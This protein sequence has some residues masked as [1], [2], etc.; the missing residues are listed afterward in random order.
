M[1]VLI[2]NKI[3]HTTENK[4]KQGSKQNPIE[5]RPFSFS[6]CRLRTKNTTEALRPFFS[7]LAFFTPQVKIQGGKRKM[8]ADKYFVAEF[9]STCTWVIEEGVYTEN[10]N[11][12][13]C[14]QQ[15]TTLAVAT[16]LPAVPTFTENCWKPG[17]KETARLDACSWNK[18]LWSE[19]KTHRLSQDNILINQPEKRG[20]SRCP[21]F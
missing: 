21:W 1:K 5:D 19:F 3:L 10:L 2:Q 18:G 12:T 4:L 17:M 16:T 13:M 11:T 15:W 9:R 8:L 6:S 14:D 20:V 7:P